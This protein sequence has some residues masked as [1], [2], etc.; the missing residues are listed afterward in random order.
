MGINSRGHIVIDQSAYPRPCLKLG[1]RLSTF[2]RRRL[3]FHV[4]SLSLRSITR[5]FE[6][7]F[8]IT[9]HGVAAYC[10]RAD[11]EIVV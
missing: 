6:G 8:L 4:Y 9:R 3:V 10:H 11:I 5:E 7:E 2:R 1:R